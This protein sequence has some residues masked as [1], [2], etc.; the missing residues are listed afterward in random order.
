MSA[1]L[2]WRSPLYAHFAN[3]NLA[4]EWLTLA[5]AQTPAALRD[6]G[7]AADLAFADISALPRLGAKG[8]AAAG[9]AA[10][11]LAAN[12]C[13]VLAGGVVAARLSADEWLFADALGLGATGGKGAALPQVEEA[14]FLPRRDTHFCFGLCGARLPQ[15][16][17]RLCALPPP[18]VGEVQ[19]TIVAGVGGVLLPL[20]PTALLWLAD[21]ARAVY[22]W[23]ALTTTGERLSAAAVGLRAWQKAA[24]K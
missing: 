19:Q 20:A 8:G 22:A 23:E 1:P 16:L 3:G 5:G 18:Q 4:T 12:A 17:S 6:E 13:A 11:A 14:N 15:L 24:Q 21:S 7:D 9:K 2:V 10:G